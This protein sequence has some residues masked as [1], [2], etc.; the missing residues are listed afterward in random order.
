MKSSKESWKKICKNGEIINL[1][2][3][4]TL[5]ALIQNIDSTCETTQSE[6]I[7]SV[8]KGLTIRNW[9]IGYYIVEFEQNGKDRAT[10]GD[11]LIEN[12]AKNLSH[13]KGMSKT[14]LKLF[15]IFYITY[16]QIG[17]TVSDQFKIEHKKSHTI[18]EKSLLVPI[19]KLKDIK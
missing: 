7:R 3:A 14:N 5:S 11:K 16:P 17:Q 6:A 19:E 8:S 4:T 1:K 12:I 13:K 15:K 9:L 10:Y 18:S 2:V